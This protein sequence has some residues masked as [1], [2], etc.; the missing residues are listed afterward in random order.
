MKEIDVQELA[1]NRS[2][3]LLLDVREPEELRTASIAGATHM[4]MGEVAS[5]LGELP[6]DRPIAVLCHHGS[7]S[8]AVAAFLTDNG[9]NAFNVAGGIDA[10]AL[11]V[12]RAIPR[13]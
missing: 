2:G 7:R 9:L 1:G 13:Y 10:Y 6:P 8:A 3:Y 12:D 5:R 11:R 4:P